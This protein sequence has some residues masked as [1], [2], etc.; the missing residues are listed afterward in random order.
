MGSSSQYFWLQY[1]ADPH[2][3]TSISRTQPP[4][5][6]TVL[7]NLLLEMS[8]PYPISPEE[9]TNHTLMTVV[10][11]LRAQLTSMSRRQDE[12]I[13]LVLDLRQELTARVEP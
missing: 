5:N 6:L 11:D 10:I 3:F 1:P 12:L 2:N 8:S 13:Q 9:V 4:A 7:S